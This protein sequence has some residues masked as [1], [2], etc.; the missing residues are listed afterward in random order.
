MSMD[1]DFSE[2]LALADE[3]AEAGPKVE[4]VSSAKLSEVA[5]KLRDDA[6]TAA[7]VDT[8]ALQASI[9]LRGGRDVRY[10]GSDIR[11]GSF[12]EFGTSKMSPRPWLFPAAGRAQ[13]RLL[14][15]F[16]ELGD[17]FA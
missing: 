12:V 13:E 15:E 7:P 5:A 2:V 4:K 16:R 10:V 1:A 8:G 14:D 6:K 3:L 17:P 9:Y 11:Y